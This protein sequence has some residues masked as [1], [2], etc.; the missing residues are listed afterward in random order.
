[1]KSLRK[2]LLLENPD[3]PRHGTLHGYSNY[4]CYCVPCRKAG[5]EYHNAAHAE[6]VKKGLAPDDPRHGTP[7]GYGNYG[8]RCTPCVD[9]R[10]EARVRW[11]ANAWQKGVQI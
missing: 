2:P 7:G 10:A 1:M 4:H 8:C 9:A 5:R 6:K 3:D 11:K